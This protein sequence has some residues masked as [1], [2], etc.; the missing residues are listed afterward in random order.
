MHIDWTS[1]GVGVVVALV[2]VLV[3]WLI[4]KYAFKESY[5][6]GLVQVEQQV[7]AHRAAILQRFSSPSDRANL[8]QAMSFADASV[9]AANSGDV[10]QSISSLTSAV[11][12]LVKVSP[13]GVAGV[14][15][16][17]PS[18]DRLMVSTILNG[19]VAPA[20]PKIQDLANTLPAFV[21]WS[22][23]VLGKVPACGQ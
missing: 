1:F 9:K 6:N 2:V 4:Y 5:T 14:V 20:I 3:I 13:A 7:A 19:K 23:A 22:Q 15:P 16:C 11:K 8:S 21:T 18:G 12:A 10:E 17:L